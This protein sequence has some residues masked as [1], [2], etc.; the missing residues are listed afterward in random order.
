MKQGWPS[1][2]DALQFSVDELCAATAVD[3]HNARCPPAAR[4][5]TSC[6]VLRGLQG[7]VVDAYRS[8]GDLLE[9]QWQQLYSEDYCRRTL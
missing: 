4:L 5:L 6:T 3:V 9:G 7:P 2:A 1:A 8:Q